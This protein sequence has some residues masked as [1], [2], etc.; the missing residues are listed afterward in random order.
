MD[1]QWGFQRQTHHIG[2]LQLADDV[3]LFINLGQTL[4]GHV[5]G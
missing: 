4:K 5:S 1:S 3:N 2:T